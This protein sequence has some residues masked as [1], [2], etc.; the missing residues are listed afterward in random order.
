MR[1][2][3]VL[4]YKM[5]TEHGSIKE[6]WSF[7]LEQMFCRTSSPKSGGYIFICTLSKKARDEYEIYPLAY[8]FIKK[9]LINFYIFLFS[10]KIM[11]SWKRTFSTECP[12][13]RWPELLYNF[14]ASKNR[15]H[16]PR[17]FYIRG[18]AWV[19]FNFCVPK[20]IMHLEDFVKE[21]KKPTYCI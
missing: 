9:F 15:N 10:I 18:H 1:T 16:F 5:W 17:S 13:S 4:L 11:V 7:A 6:V 8:V 3:I 2:F 14:K 21:K 19:S 12:P 20:S